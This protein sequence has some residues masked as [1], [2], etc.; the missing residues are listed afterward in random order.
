MNEK[1]LQIACNVACLLV[2]AFVALFKK[3]PVLTETVA[4]AQ[5]VVIVTGALGAF[6]LVYPYIDR[7]ITTREM[8]FPT[9]LGLAS[10]A[11]A[12]VL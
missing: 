6:N 9:G 1:L 11:I 10:A 4:D 5:M 7:R 3:E 12:L 2:F 8:W